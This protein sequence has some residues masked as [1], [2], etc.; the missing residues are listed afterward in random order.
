[1]MSTLINDV[2]YALRGFRRTPLFT[3]VAVVSLAFGIG[4]NTAIFSLLDQILLRLL[5]VKDPGQ[6]VILVERG[7][8]YGSNWG[9]NALSYP[10]Y[11]DFSAHNN[12]FSGMFC[13]FPFAASLGYGGRTERIGAELVS[14]TYFPVLGVGASAGRVFGPSDD[15]KPGGH[16]VAILSNA[17]WQS[18]FGSNPGVIGQDLVINGHSMTVV[19]VAQPGFDGVE[20]GQEA[21]VFVPVQMAEQMI[22][23]FE[24]TMQ[25]RRTRWINA[26]GRLKPGVTRE[27]AKAALQP[28]MH[29]ML[30]MEV[31]ESAFRNAAEETRKSFLKS[32]IDPQPG[33]QG[34]SYMRRQLQTPL[35]LLMG[36]TGA[37]LLL[38]CANIANLMLAR[39]GARSREMAIR[40]AIGASRGN[41]IRLL[42]VESLLLSAFGAL[43][44]LVFAFLADHVLLSIFL[45]EDAQRIKI[46]ATPDL[47]VLLFTLGILL[48]TSLLFGLAPAIQSARA[49]VS[50]TLKEQAGSVVGGGSV[51]LRKTLVTAQ[52][53]LSL[54]LLIG[55]GMFVQTLGNLRN[56]GPGFSPER[57]LG[58][59]IDPSLNGYTA[60]RSKAFYR[61]LTEDLTAL[62]GVRSV[63]LAQ[64]RI[65]EDDEWDSSMTAEG[66]NVS[67]RHSPEPYM[68]RIS[69]GY[70]ATMG[71]PVVAGRDFTLRDV[72]E[73]KHSPE[74]DDWNP[75][76]A[77]INEKFARKYF[78]GRNPL[79]RH[80]GF[81]SD[82][83]TKTDIE[84]VGVVKDVK[85]TN[86][87]D[88]IPEQVFL[89]Y[90]AERRSGSMTVY[91]RTNLEPKQVMAEVRRRVRTLDANI[92]IYGMRTQNEQIDRSLRTE[93]LVA[94]LSAVFGLLATLLA[95]VGLYG[96]MSYTVARRTREIGIRLALGADGAHVL[97]M[98]MR[99]VLVLVAIGVAIAI[100]LSVAFTRAIRSQLFGLAPHDPFTILLA[101]VLLTAAAAAAG[102]IP[103]LRASRIAPTQ[104]LRYE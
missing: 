28:F 53:T 27:K 95:V 97:W 41:I 10:M 72:T 35:W 43:L 77:V 14:G 48:L 39:A 2:R 70:F 87:R 26:F 32:T 1:M 91:L 98:I 81:G 54:L 66:Y 45:G 78:A 104:A 25:N 16:P 85:Y 49:Q 69:P 52:V 24:R 7:S 100:P 82:P 80:I 86:L 79:G 38:A 50:S 17:F 101:V 9:M 5:P 8:H 31:R 56:L 58:F 92:P 60:E 99:E 61:R 64:V 29:S 74:P 67:Q 46:S 93:R 19:G 88:E 22:P 23:N 6:L 75:D 65:L 89:P 34:R 73:V 40:L 18:R 21:K 83:G 94:S 15:R 62:P 102:L 59:D 47:R 4:A 63:A 37:V 44:G 84:I 76:K 13:R 51:W 36:I 12:V 33:S 96:V 11:R 103:A 71:I 42:L 90:L 55:A 30:E 3:V 57:L 20:M 68:N